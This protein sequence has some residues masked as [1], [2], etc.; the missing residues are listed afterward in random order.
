M[1]WLLSDSCYATALYG[2]WHLGAVEERRSGAPD[3]GPH[4][5]EF[6]GKVNWVQIDLK[7]ADHDHPD[8]AR[9][10]L[11]GLARRPRRSECEPLATARTRV[12]D[13]RAGCLDA[14]DYGCQATDELHA[15]FKLTSFMLTCT[16]AK[17]W[18]ARSAAPM[19][20]FWPEGRD[21]RRP[22]STQVRDFGGT[23]NCRALSSRRDSEM[24]AT[25]FI[26][27]ETGLPCPLVR[28]LQLPCPCR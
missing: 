10:A 24:C 2:K 3:Y 27:S 14:R 19:H 25:V 16:Q 13:T 11:P 22:K 21:W 28:H 9:G 5:N 1:P 15:R 12:P 20:A 6:S 23:P 8:R 7:K 26:F 17:F 4:G 18:R